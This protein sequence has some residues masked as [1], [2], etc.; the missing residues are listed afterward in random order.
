MGTRYGG[1]GATHRTTMTCEVIFFYLTNNFR[2]GIYK[3]TTN[4]FT[5]CVQ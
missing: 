4:I 3:P 2:H 5:I 1:D